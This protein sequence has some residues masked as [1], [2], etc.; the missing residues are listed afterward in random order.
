MTQS[1]AARMDGDA[2]R[3]WVF[4][5]PTL[6]R[7]DVQGLL[8]EARILPPIAA[9]DLWNLPIRSGD[10]L[11]IID[12]FFLQCRSIR[13]KELID[14]MNRGV[15]V[16]GA[17]SLG[18]LR[19]AEL[20][21]AGMIGLG[22]IFDWYADGM[23]EGDDEVAVVHRDASEGFRQVTR[24]LVDLRATFDRAVA[25]GAMTEETA[26]EL[27]ATV[28]SMPFGL[29]D[30]DSIL[31][32]LGSSSGPLVAESY[33]Q[34]VR[35]SWVDAKAMD[36]RMLLR[37]IASN[38]LP[39]SRADLPAHEAEC[40]VSRVTLFPDWTVSERAELTDDGERVLGWQVLAA[41]R[42]FDANFPLVMEEAAVAAALHDAVARG[43]DDAREKHNALDIHQADD[44]DRA[45]IALFVSR[46]L[47]DSAD[48]VGTLLR[49]TE[50][51]LF[52]NE[53]ETLTNAERVRRFVR[54][55]HGAPWRSPAVAQVLRDRGEWERWREVAAAI[56][57]FNALVRARRPSFNHHAIPEDQ[58]RAWCA[59]RWLGESE[60]DMRS[61]RV[62]LADRGYST[63]GRWRADARWVFPFAKLRSD[64][65]PDLAR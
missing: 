27:V 35:N 36:A 44:V 8:P 14:A 47:V 9:G 53:V 30:D 52:E 7:A 11:A 46:G 41:A 48:S 40:V 54:R 49:M 20:H 4:V 56:N 34:A 62:V 42:T 51:L 10:T 33:R 21:R 13:H 1:A 5:G 45:L 6:A 25:I 55:T 15:R 24:A 60:P 58:M 57:G 37:S 3:T 19:A 18:A 2:A 23:I 26:A 29:R 59:E 63:E 31:E 61:W 17:A 22:V 12:G 50:P 43:N 38:V 39:E 16:A 28:G 32:R 64:R 65:H